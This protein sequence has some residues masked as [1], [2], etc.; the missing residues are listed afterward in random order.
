LVR[1][2]GELSDCVSPCNRWYLIS[3]IGRNSQGIRQAAYAALL[4]QVCL[5]RSLS[6]NGYGCLRPREPFRRETSA[7]QVQWYYPLPCH[8]DLVSSTDVFAELPKIVD[9]KAKL[10]SIPQDSLERE[11]IDGGEI[12]HVANFDLETR[13]N[14]ANTLTFRLIHAGRTYDEETVQT[15]FI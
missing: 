8:R 15:E 1:S 3:A 12:L 6:A 5:G 14:S 7:V 11:T 13:L 2:T 10:D 4:T 9:L